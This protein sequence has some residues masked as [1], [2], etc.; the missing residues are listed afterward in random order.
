LKTF[1]IW[2]TRHHQD[3]SITWISGTGRSYVSQTREWATG[4]ALGAVPIDDPQRT[5]N[6]LIDGSGSATDPGDP[7]TGPGGHHDDDPPF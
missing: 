1:G 4:L 2:D 7:S 3:G 5:T 6:K